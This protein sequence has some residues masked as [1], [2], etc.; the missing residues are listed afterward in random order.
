MKK[1][2]VWLTSP[3]VG[4]DAMPSARRIIAFAI[5]AGAYRYC[6]HGY[7]NACDLEPMVLGTFFGGAA[8]MLGISTAQNIFDNRV[9]KKENE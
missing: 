9:K 5:I 7:K 3:I 2:F 1:A 6:E 8:L 4:T